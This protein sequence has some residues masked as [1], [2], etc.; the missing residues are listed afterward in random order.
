MKQSGKLFAL[1][2]LFLGTSVFYGC[3]EES[4]PL[5]TVPQTTVRSYLN[6]L[7]LFNLSYEEELTTDDYSNLKSAQLTGCVTVTLH[8]NADGQ[9]WPRSWTLDYGAENCQC[10]SGNTKRGKIHVSLSDWWRKE[11]SLRKITFENFYLNDNKLEGIKTI[12]NTGLNENGNLTFSKNLDNAKLTYPDG[13]VMSWKCEKI[14]EL[15]EGGD[16]YIFADDVWSVTGSGSGKNLDGKNYTMTIKS[17]LIYQ[18]GCFYPV[19]GI[20]EIETE[21]ETPKIID[22]GNGECDNE[23]SVTADGETEIIQL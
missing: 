5:D 23:A 11:G 2:I 15:I 20:I 7:D 3:K 21:G 6:M 12:L 4:L 13:T 14:S 8:E 16:S 1:V 18:N 9:F 10:Y 22:Y 17:P 19:S